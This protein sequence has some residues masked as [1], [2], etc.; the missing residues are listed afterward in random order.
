MN[1]NFCL[2]AIFVLWLA[3]CAGPRE[4]YVLL[5]DA[6][7]KTGT[8]TVT[9]KSGPPLQIA[10]A[11][12]TATAT[13]GKA[14][15][16]KTDEQATKEMFAE[17][18]SAQPQQ[19]LRFTLYFREGSDELTVESKQKIEEVFTAVRQRPA[20]DIVVVGHTDRV[21]QVADNDRLAL[22]RAEKIRG[23]LIRQGIAAENV[24][25]AGRGEREPL[26][27]TADE[28]AEPRNRRVEILVR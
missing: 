25:A 5:P 13:S 14:A 1:K 3:A 15:P 18:L 6:E 7:G 10:G 21:G 9:P 2:L 27:P 24:Q 23:D 12:A 19:P 28:I 8:L 20:P 26:V 11:Y 22:R 17:A 16:A 4:T